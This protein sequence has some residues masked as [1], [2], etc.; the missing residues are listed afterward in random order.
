MIAA[1]D[2][3]LCNDTYLDAYVP[4]TT[5]QQFFKLPSVVSVLTSQRPISDVS[6]ITEPANIA[7]VPASTDVPA[8]KRL[9]DVA[10]IGPTTD[11]PLD[12]SDVPGSIEFADC[13]SAAADVGICV[14]VPVFR[15]Q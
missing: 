14:A 3:Y 10:V 15:C 12:L 13:V 9:C 6:N 5:K 11:V 1:Y 8:P 4:S 2:T 7:V